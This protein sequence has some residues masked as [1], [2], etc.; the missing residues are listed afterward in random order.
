MSLLTPSFGLLVWM[1]LSFAIVFVLLAKFGFPIITQS[2]KERKDYID[3]S[4]AKADE[5]NRVLASIQQQSDQLIDEVHKQQ[6][7][8]IKDATVEADRILQKAKEDAIRLNKQKLDE[9][10][11]LIELQKQKAI[12]EIRTQVALMSVAVAEKILRRQLDITENHHQLV[13]QLLDEIENA[14]IIMN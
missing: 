9:S 6:K 8:I 7:D 13:S 12:G 5:A 3:Q 2:V 1:V 11:R 10:L 4:L 14:N